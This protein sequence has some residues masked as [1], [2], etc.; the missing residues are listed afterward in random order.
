VRRFLAALAMPS[1]HDGRQPGTPEVQQG[2]RCAL[3]SFCCQ[4]GERHDGTH[5]NVVPAARAKL[6]SDPLKAG[7]HDPTGRGNVGGRTKPT[8]DLALSRFTLERFSGVA[9]SG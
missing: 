9:A 7:E 3:M 8:D 2:S 5:G 6:G 1:G 4:M